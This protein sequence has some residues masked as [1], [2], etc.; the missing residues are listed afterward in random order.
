MQIDAGWYDPAASWGCWV[1]PL[2]VLEARRSW[3]RRMK[4][5][6]PVGRPTMIGHRSELADVVGLRNG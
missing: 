6:R 5:L 1:V 4:L 2:G 3:S